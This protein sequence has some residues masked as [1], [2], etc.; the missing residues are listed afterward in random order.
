MTLRRFGL[1]MGIGLTNI[2]F[3]SETGFGFRRNYGNVWTY[4]SFQFQINKNKIAIW[5]FQMDFKKSFCWHFDPNNNDIIYF[6]VDRSENGWG[7]WHVLVW[8]KFRIWR[9]GQHTPTKNSQGYP[10][11]PPPPAGQERIGVIA[12]EANIFKAQWIT[13]SDLFSDPKKSLVSTLGG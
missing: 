4:L 2:L 13:W 8:N 1:H 9:T 11:P 7:K 10:P 5:E 6:L 12:I 3:L